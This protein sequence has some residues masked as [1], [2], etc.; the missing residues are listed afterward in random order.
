MSSP[1]EFS[2]R[3]TCVERAAN[4]SLLA[5]VVSSVARISAAVVVGISALSAGVPYLGGM[6]TNATTGFQNS[7]SGEDSRF[8]EDR[9]AAMSAKYGGGI[10]F[11]N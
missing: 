1:W 10:N 7:G 9:M 3:G 6:N 2:W 5:A 11:Y 4:Q 8:F